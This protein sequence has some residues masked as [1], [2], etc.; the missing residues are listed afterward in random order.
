MSVPKNFLYFESPAWANLIIQ[1][2][3]TEPCIRH[4]ALAL[5][6]M[7]RYEY[8]RHSQ[9]QTSSKLTLDYSMK[10]YNLAIRALNEALDGLTRSLELAILG[11]IVFIAFEV[12]WGADIRVKMHM[13]G[14]YSILDSLTKTNLWY[15]RAYSQCLVTAL[16]QLSGQ[17]SLFGTLTAGNGKENENENETA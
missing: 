14:A 16:K 10:Q 1:A 5:G 6:A 13:N 11:S 2:A 4:T 12:L 7:S 17:I 15:T 9:S 3:Y 8:H